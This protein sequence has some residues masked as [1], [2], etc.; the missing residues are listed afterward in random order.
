MTYT[1]TITLTE[2]QSTLTKIITTLRKLQTEI[3]MFHLEKEQNTNESFIDMEIQTKSTLT[4]LEK[5]LARVEGVHDV[6]NTTR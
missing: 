6:C 4:L 5:S 3:K 2:S 1:F